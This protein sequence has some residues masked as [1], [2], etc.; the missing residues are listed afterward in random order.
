MSESIIAQT[1]TD[2]VKTIQSMGTEL[3]EEL[4]KVSDAMVRALKAGNKV[5]AMGNGGS[6][7]DAQHLAGELI[8][9]F[10]EERIALA[11]I[12]LTADTSILTAVANDYGYEAVFLRQVEGL[13]RSGDVVVGIST[14]GNSANVISALAR[15]KEL[16]CVTVGLTGADG[17]EI[18]KM[19]DYSLATPSS[20]TPRIQEG[21][22]L[23]IHI[24]CD[25]VE[26]QFL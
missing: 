6:A 23:L 10:L 20:E 24:L 1:L 7:A 18:G 26:K 11:A 15:A 4:E 14:S 2:H 9:R 16:R 17:G 22:I 25:L 3:A 13:A 19:T 8:G 12:A 5:L 21:H